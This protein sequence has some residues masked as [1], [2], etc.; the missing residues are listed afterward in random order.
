MD[1]I[2]GLPQTESGFDSIVVFVD[3]LT[4]MVHLAPCTKGLTADGVASLFMDNVF[5]H[6]GVPAKIISDR[7]TK[8]TADFWREVTKRLGSKCNFSTANHPQT[9]GQTERYNRVLEEVLRNFVSPTM[10]N[11]AELLPCCEFALNSHVHKSTTYSPFFLN[12]G[13]NP[14]RPIDLAF[15]GAF[16]ED[17]LE[18][19]Q[20][21]TSHMT[22]GQRGATKR[23]HKI[24]MALQRVQRLLASANE[25]MARREAAH[26]RTVHEKFTEG[27]MVWLNSRNFTWKSGARKLCPK[28]L[29][30]FTI[31]QKLGPV[32]FKLDLPSDWRM[33]PVFHV[34]LLKPFEKG[35]DYKA[36]RPVRVIDGEP[37]WEVEAIVKHR[38]TSHGAT[39]FL[40]H[41]KG[42]GR[43][44]QTWL[45]EQNLEH[46]K[47]QR[48]R[49]MRS[50]HSNPEFGR[51]DTDL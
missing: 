12:Y 38:Y 26:F 37:E 13:R 25:A 15:E 32:T 51:V 46:A 44:W 40:V 10:T 14:T 48:D 4:K 20:D 7:D 31:V 11:W 18:V 30:P 19:Q 42:F 16:E 1:F 43:E 27:S 39:E 2:T 23:I 50:I 34:S 35:P 28:W 8:L 3:K 45:P 24:H 49:Y 22:P 33:H 21:D 41:W 5:R 6:H 9:D 36:P 17:T 29:G 47:R